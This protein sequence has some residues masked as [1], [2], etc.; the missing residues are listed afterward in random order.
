MCQINGDENWVKSGE[1]LSINELRRKDNLVR[2][3]LLT[4]SLTWSNWKSSEVGVDHNSMTN[5]YAELFSY[6][7]VQSDVTLE[8][9]EPAWHQ[10]SRPVQGITENC[11]KFNGEWLV[12]WTY[13]MKWDIDRY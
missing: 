4:T 10:R 7:Q 13:E 11:E 6:H 9:R 3:V 1:L 2:Q 8:I 5:Q 12:A